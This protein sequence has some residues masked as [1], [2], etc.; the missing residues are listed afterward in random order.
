VEL[1]FEALLGRISIP[2][3]FETLSKYPTVERDLSVLV[4]RDISYG[5]IRKGILELGLTKLIGMDLLDVYSGGK[6]PKDKVSM[7]MRFLFQDPEGTLTV[8]QVQGYSDNI[9]SFLRTHYGAELR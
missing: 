7:M 1:D 6:I 3:K 8:D 2:L 9:Q 4:S 5:S